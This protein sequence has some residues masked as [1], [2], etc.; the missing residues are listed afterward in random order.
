MNFFAYDFIKNAL[1]A[2]FLS[3]LMC[4]LMGT[5]VVTKRLVFISGGISHAAFGGLGL[6][7]LLGLN[8]IPGA[9]L[10]AI[11]I[12]LILGSYKPSKINAQDAYIGILWSVGMA[13]G[14]VFI[15]LSP[16]S[17]APNLMSYLFGDILMVSSKALVGMSVLTVGM[18][19]LIFG[20]FKYFLSIVFDEE[21][22]QLQN[23]PVRKV[24]MLLFVM[25]GLTVVTLIQLVG[26]ILVIAL[27][28]IP[29]ML[30]MLFF[31]DFK[32]VL[33]FSGL[34]SI[35]ITQSGIILSF[36]LNLPTGPV[37]I[38][39]GAFLLVVSY[40]IKGFGRQKFELKKQ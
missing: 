40:L 14:I 18:L 28:T 31:N 12:S 39:L 15:H 6:F 23:I 27:L 25:I 4:G 3:S 35:L 24:R 2:G 38:L 22:S 1:L 33:F 17:Y 32:K 30:S 20:F 29:P 10:V 7:F 37:I 8:P 13:A 21:F 9:Y 16:Q 26:I 5:F 19:A 36:Y 11:I 34:F